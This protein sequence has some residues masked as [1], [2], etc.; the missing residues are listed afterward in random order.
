MS[1]DSHVDRSIDGVLSAVLFLLL[2]NCV[3]WFSRR[4]HRQCTFFILASPSPFFPMVSE[5][6]ASFFLFSI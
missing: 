1:L 4:I 2:N 6:A 3:L 5:V